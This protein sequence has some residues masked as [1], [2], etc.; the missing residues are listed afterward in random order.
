MLISG[1]ARSCV[2]FGPKFGAIIVKRRR[3]MRK[4]FACNKYLPVA[5]ALGAFAALGP[6]PAFAQSFNRTEGTGNVLPSYYDSN[7]GIHAGIAPQQNQIAAH[8]SGLSA[9]ARVPRAA[10][11]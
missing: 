5:L 9:F 11:R 3:D 1:V 2:R 10:Q 8:R 6:A 4:L 7:G